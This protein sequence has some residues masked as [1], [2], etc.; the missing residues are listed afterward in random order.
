MSHRN[1]SIRLAS[2]GFLPTG[3]GFYVVLTSA[4]ASR[5]DSC[6]PIARRSTFYCLA[7]V[8]CRN[9]TANPY[10][11]SNASR[12]NMAK[13]DM[14]K[15]PVPPVQEDDFR[16]VG[17]ASDKTS[18]AS[19]LWPAT[20]AAITDS[21]NGGTRPAGISCEKKCGKITRRNLAHQ[22]CRARKR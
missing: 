1:Y 22:H 20:T 4:L 8:R 2:N 7:N 13:S 14:R 11:R 17:G 21:R 6:E 19:T 16:P 18:H 9:P 15:I 12:V 5:Q 3:A 10:I